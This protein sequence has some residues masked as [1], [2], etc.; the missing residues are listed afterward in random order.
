MFDGTEMPFKVRC[1]KIQQRENIFAYNKH[2]LGNK[3]L[4]V[5]S[6]R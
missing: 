2:A 3:V 5:M 4:Y 6:N 1:A